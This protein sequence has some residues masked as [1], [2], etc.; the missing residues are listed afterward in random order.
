[1]L[2]LSL[3]QCN[4]CRVNLPDQIELRGVRNRAQSPK[5]TNY[6]QFRQILPVFQ[7]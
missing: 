5:I 1:M 7:Q 3:T 4:T 2:R 6:S